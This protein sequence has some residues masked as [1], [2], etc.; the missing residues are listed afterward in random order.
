MAPAQPVA[1][2][3][4]VAPAEPAQPEEPAARA[5]TA[6]PVAAAVLA[7]LLIQLLIRAGRVEPGAA[8]GIVDRKS[9]G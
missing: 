7:V 9:G 2:E 3:E 6:Q 1:P 4:R 5:E 8:R